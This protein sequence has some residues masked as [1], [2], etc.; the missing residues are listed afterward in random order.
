MIASGS[1][2]ATASPI[3]EPSRPS[4]TTASAPIAWMASLDFSLVVVPVTWWP[5]ATSIGTSRRPT[6]PLAPATKTR[7]VGLLSHLC[8]QDETGGQGVKGAID[9]R[10]LS[11]IAMIVNHENDHAARPTAVAGADPRRSVCR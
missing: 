7:M 1:A 3:P 9:R 10:A 11:A 2:L 8:P 6:A 5:R 4:T